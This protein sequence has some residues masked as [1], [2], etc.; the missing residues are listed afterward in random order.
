MNRQ[1]WASAVVTGAL[2]CLMTLG[3]MPF[4]LMMPG[5]APVG[6]AP[7]PEHCAVPDHF[8]EVD[9][10]LP[11]VAIMAAERRIDI[12]V[13]GTGSSMLPGAEGTSRA[14][15]A[16]LQAALADRLPGVEV[17]VRADV[18]SRR[19]TAE[20]AASLATLPAAEMPGLVIWQT[21]TVEAMRQ[22]EPEGLRAELETAVARLR[23]AGIDVLLVN[24]QYSPRTDMIITE[25]PYAEAMQW[26]A[27]QAEVPLFDRLGVMRYWSQNGI[28]D[29]AGGNRMQIAERVHDCIGRLL[30]QII[31][32]N[33]ALHLAKSRVSH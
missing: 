2:S 32:H 31:I 16:R 23:K 22:M 29:L 20:M 26:V 28:F 12:L 33:A 15:P 19:T 24:M 7:I 5:A 30:A 14:Y 10:M 11:R 18:K 3:V 9:G 6:L 17:R 13:L 4:G 8:V 27:Q 1:F 25:Q 21:G